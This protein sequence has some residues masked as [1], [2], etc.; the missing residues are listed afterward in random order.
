MLQ[1]FFVTL[2]FTFLIDS[3]IN[4]FFTMIPELAEFE[5]QLFDM[6]G[7][8]SAISNTSSIEY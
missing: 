1:E 7:Q 6:E 2:L 4:S 8:L 3:V 5:N